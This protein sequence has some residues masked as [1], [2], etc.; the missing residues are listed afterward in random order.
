MAD[1]A[2]VH[3]YRMQTA[4]VVAAPWPRRKS[5]DKIAGLF[6]FIA[7]VEVK[8]FLQKGGKRGLKSA[9]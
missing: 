6:L 2:P 8:K 7:E 5:E 4:V 9:T 3:K 1:T